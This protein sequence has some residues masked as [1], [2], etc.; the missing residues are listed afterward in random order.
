MYYKIRFFRIA[1]RFLNAAKIDLHELADL[2]KSLGYTVAAQLPPR[3]FKASIGGSGPIAAKGNIIVDV[4]TEKLVVGV[5]SVDETCINEFILIE[6]AITANFD[7]LKGERFY[8]LLA[9][10][11]IKSE[12]IKPMEL[13]W[14]VSKENIV[15]KKISSALGEPLFVFGYRLTKE[16]ASPE[17]SEWIDIEIMPH[18]MK[19]RAS[20]Y[21]SIVYRSKNREKVLEASKRL[22]AIANA[23]KDLMKNER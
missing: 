13:F 9:E 21:A 19:P 16:E 7:V 18:L 8:E 12:E 3:S 2:F 20:I 4:N 23:V 14:K 6:K 17:S 11:E 22:E 1:V 10:L 15:A 5:T